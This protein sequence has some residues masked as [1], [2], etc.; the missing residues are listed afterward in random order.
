MLQLHDL[1]PREERHLNGSRFLEDPPI[2]ELQASS[3]LS[4]FP[5]HRGTEQAMVNIYT[6]PRLPCTLFAHAHILEA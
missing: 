1:A 4:R 5:Y 2:I 6:S 3:R